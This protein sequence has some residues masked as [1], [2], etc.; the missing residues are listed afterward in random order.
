MAGIVWMY[1]GRM[2]SGIGYPHFVE[3]FSALVLLGGI[4]VFCIFFFYIFDKSYK[5]QI[6]RITEKY[7]TRAYIWQFFDLTSYIIMFVMIT[8][9]VALRNSGLL[10]SQV[11]AS[12]YSGIG[13]ALFL[14][15]VR[16][17]FA[18]IRKKVLKP[19]QN[20]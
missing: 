3:Q 9:G 13:S 15:G 4:A 6:S 8:F 7:A 19:K 2:V 20:T 17:V 5:K 11:I 14:S 10:S 18:F 16:Y 12:M 1:A